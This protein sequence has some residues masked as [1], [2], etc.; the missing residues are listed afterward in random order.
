M[1][2][3]YMLDVTRGKVPKLEEIFA[4][5][6]KL[7]SLGYSHLEL[8]IEH[9]FMFEGK[10][11]AWRDASPLSPDDIKKIDSYAKSK[12]IELV[13]NCN[14]F[15]H[16]E[17]FLKHD[18]FKHLAEC[19]PPYYQED[20]KAYRQGVIVVDEAGL[21]FVD[22]LLASYTKY[23]ESD[24][25]NIG[26]D[27]TFELGMGRCQEYCKKVGKGRLYLEGL[28]K[29]YKLAKNYAENIYFWGDI[30]LKYP[31]LISELPKDATVLNW[32]Y[33]DN[34]PFAEE[35]E[36]I[37]DSGLKFIVCPGTSSWNSVAG[38][39]KNMLGNIISAQINAEKN[40]AEGILLTDWGDRGHMQYPY[41]SYAGICAA[42][43]A[44]HEGAENLTEAKVIA[45]VNEVFFND[46]NSPFGEIILEL[47]H[48]HEVFKTKR[49]NVT[50]F[51][52][53]LIY[54]D[55]PG[56][57]IFMDGITK[58]EIDEAARNFEILKNK[59]EKVEN[60]SLVC[61]EMKNTLRLVEVAIA[62]LYQNKNLPYDKVK[63]Y[64]LVTEAIAEHCALWL[65]RNRI[66]GME[67]GL[68]HLEKARNSFLK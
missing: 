40:G 9:A 47:G 11:S 23:F 51:N 65:E 25:L 42:S 18:E 10:K 35:T 54:E 3:G 17:R 64:Q 36:K 48:L 67:E 14:T 60:N 30:I 32:G 43:I 50:L 39:S 68:G 26:C 45:K 33:E 31:E 24:K 59:F 53:G 63:A 6:D 41:L 46:K 20:A 15:G 49:I 8:Y 58:E 16:L 28:Q 34:H 22:S 13:P 2:L 5:I 61:R 62:R 12:G 55:Y 19:D 29:I 38:R 1:F 57:P 56:G 52:V 4:L 7:S 37:A 44:F 66:G 21:N 27:E